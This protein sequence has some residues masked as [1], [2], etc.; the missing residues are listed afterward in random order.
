MTTTNGLP[1]Q[2]IGIKFPALI[3]ALLLT[4][5]A[6]AQPQQSIAQSPQTTQQASQS[7]QAQSSQSAPASQPA[8]AADGDNAPVP[9][10][11]PDPAESAAPS[12]DLLHDN[13]VPDTPVPDSLL[14]DS[15]GA[16]QSAQLETQEPAGTQQSTQS[17]PAAAPSAQPAVPPLPAPLPK[18]PL[19][20]AAAE[21]VPTMGV[22]A[23]RPAGAALAPGK[24]RRIRSFLIRTG[25]IVGAAAALGITMA[26]TEASPSKPPGAH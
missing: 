23:S 9:P 8:P 22:A 24:Q 13:R 16:I 12:N 14:P 4:P 6:Y 11:P 19:G 18:E 10:M 20:T 21:T 5:L 15:P 26:L 7:T 3:L 17:Q 1:L 2:G 25:A